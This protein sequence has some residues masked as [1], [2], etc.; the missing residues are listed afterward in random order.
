MRSTYHKYRRSVAYVAVKNSAGEE[1]IGSAF[2]IG[3]GFF[4]TAKH[5]LEKKKLVEICIT[6]PLRVL[7][8][9]HGNLLAEQERPVLLTLSSAPVFAEEG[10]DIAIFQA[11]NYEGIP[12]IPLCS[13]NDVNRT[14]DQALLTHVLCIGYPPIP[15]TTHPFQVAVN[16]T[17]NALV[18]VR[19]SDYLTYV[20]SS[21]ARGGF[22]GG[23]VI[24]EK[25][26]AFA[27]ATESLV[28]NDKGAESGFM[29]CLSCDA[30]VDLAIKCGWNADSAGYYRDIE[31]LVSIKMALPNTTKLNPHLYD[32]Q[33][34][35]YDDDRDV[36]LDIS[37]IKLEDRQRAYEVFNDVCPMKIERTDEMSILAT[38]L[39]NPSSK[40]LTQASL[41]VREVLSSIG[42]QV[43]SQRISPGWYPDK[44]E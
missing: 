42:Y 26:E 40:L 7:E 34:Y 20:L 33:I 37:S 8:E 35:V 23:P 36:F 9:L 13:I 29:A 5:V 28:I 43:V 14:E 3:Q 2:H 1:S 31:S 22:S 27:I 38:P 16:A 15:L 24:N 30:A 17:I 6:Q 10:I 44:I 41:S 12:S 18:R 21:T 19:A 25:E 11:K 4:V 32:A 39:H